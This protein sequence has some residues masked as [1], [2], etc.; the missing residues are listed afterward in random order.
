MGL[1]GG[2]RAA[3]HKNAMRAMMGMWEAGTSQ[4]VDGG[5]T[6]G[7]V[8]NHIFSGLASGGMSDDEIVIPLLGAT[9]PYA[10]RSVFSLCVF[11]MS[12]KHTFYSGRSSE[13]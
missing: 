8:P 6:S 7:S 2:K 13:V 5:I 9:N 1:L 10:G 11:C 12:A 4:G 3:G